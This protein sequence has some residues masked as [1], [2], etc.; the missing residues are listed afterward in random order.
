[1][2]KCI[3]ESHFITNW[4]NNEDK[5]LSQILMPCAM[6]LR[7]GIIV[8]SASLKTLGKAQ[9]FLNKIKA[10]DFKNIALIEME[11]FRVDSFL[12]LSYLFRHWEFDEQIIM[13]IESCTK[14]YRA[15]PEL[16]K[17]A[18]ALAIVNT[19]FSMHSYDKKIAIE[20]CVEIIQE[21]SAQ[22]VKF[23]LDNFVHNA[24]KVKS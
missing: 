9:E 12:F 6:L 16:K 3:L 8:F 22:G 13:T 20:R 17:S 24:Q 4:L 2:R 23:S 14:P 15:V 10:N 11:Y 19:L 21:A 5:A 18:Y 1:M 7:L